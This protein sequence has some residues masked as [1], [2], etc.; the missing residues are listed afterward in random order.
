MLCSSLK[1]RY[2]E[3]V[4]IKL[5]INITITPEKVSIMK[6]V[7]E[8]ESFGERRMISNQEPDASM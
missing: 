8:E 2:F 1:H 5:A 7:G 6:E 3:L 4:N